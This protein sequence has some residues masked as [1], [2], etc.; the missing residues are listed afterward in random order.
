MRVERLLKTATLTVGA[1]C[2]FGSLANG[3]DL[4]QRGA[5]PFDTYDTNKDGYVSQSEFYD[6]RAKR[7]SIRA[8]QGMPMRNAGNAPDFELFDKNKDGKLTNWN[9]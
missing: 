8:N 7:Q 5:M 9:F 2:L 6:T 1:V 4:S 3:A